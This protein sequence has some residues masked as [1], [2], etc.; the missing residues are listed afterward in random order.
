MD[1][2]QIILGRPW[3]FDKD[4]TIHGWSNMCWF[5]Y[6]GKKI[7]LMPLR[8]IA[9]QPKPNV[10]KKSKGVQLISVTELDQEIKNDFSFM[11]LAAT[12]VVKTP[13]SLI[14]LEVTPVIEEFS[15]VFPEE[16][17]NRLPPM[18]DI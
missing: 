8:P 2:I 5:E 15:D 18:C 11:I 16:L 1:V 14:P 10:P 3:L 17:L 12:E 4:V 6:E 9:K 7:K 13:D